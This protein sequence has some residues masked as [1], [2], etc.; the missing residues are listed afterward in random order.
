MACSDGTVDVQT[1]I[2]RA[3]QIMMDMNKF[4]QGRD[5]FGKPVQFQRDVDDRIGLAFDPESY[6]EEFGR[7][8]YNL[9][10][11]EMEEE[12]SAQSKACSGRVK[13]WLRSALGQDRYENGTVMTGLRGVRDGI[14]GRFGKWGRAA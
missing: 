14:R 10:S 5:A 1:T 9:F 2:G 8:R 12:F 11:R 3:D 4:K 6:G 13:G 7:R